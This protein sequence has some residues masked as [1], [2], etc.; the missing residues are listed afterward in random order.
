[1][2]EEKDSKLLSQKESLEDLFAEKSSVPDDGAVD[3]TIKSEVASA[4]VGAVAVKAGILI[5]KSHLWI[6]AAI[7]LALIACGFFLG[8]FLKGE[9]KDS[10]RIDPNAKAYGQIQAI[11]EN[12]NPDGISIPMFTKVIFPA[13][14]KD[15]KIVLLNPEG[16]PC[17]FRY[18]LRIAGEEE[19]YRSGLIPPGMAVTDLSLSRALEQGEYAMEIIVETYSLDDE[20]T[21]MNGATENAVLYVR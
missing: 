2:F 20:L 6:G 7:V 13:N 17:Y 12:E 10:M 4:E 14:E 5:Q 15:V 3:A 19:L 1:M 18:T 11:P 8:Y 21:P 16:N 9:H